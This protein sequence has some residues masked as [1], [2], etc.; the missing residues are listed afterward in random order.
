MNII[1]LPTVQHTGTWF[2]AEFLRR[3]SQVHQVQ[4]LWMLHD[5]FP[6][7]GL[8]VVSAHYCGDEISEE[9]GIHENDVK[10][11]F[12][13]EVLED[14]IKTFPSL[15]VTRDPLLS[16]ITRKK[17]SPELTQTYIVDG[18]VALADLCMR[19]GIMV[20]PVDLLGMRPYKVKLEALRGVLKLVGLEEEN[21]VKVWASVWPRYNHNAELEATKGITKLYKNGNA[22]AIREYFPAEYDYLVSQEDKI[23]PFLERLGYKNLMWWS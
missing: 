23:R 14:L 15:T 13:T 1:F 12:P 18:F 3:H 17:R 21:Y 7:D 2:M 5:Q 6:D 9:R 16:M 19:T 10:K 11:H 8:I 4:D 22:L 20:L